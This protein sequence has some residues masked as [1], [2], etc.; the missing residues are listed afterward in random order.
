LSIRKKSKSRKD[1]LSE[2]NKHEIDFDKQLI[3]INDNINILKKSH[4]VLIDIQKKILESNKTTI[5][6]ISMSKF[7]KLRKEPI[8]INDKTK[9]KRVKVKIHGKG[10]QL[11]DE[12]FGAEIKTKKQFM[13]KTNDLIVAEIDAKVG[14]FGII[15]PELESAIVSN[16]YFLYEIDESVM[17]PDFGLYS[18]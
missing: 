11:R 10:I 8:T 15:P 6:V 14:G 1:L 7:L 12:V 3:E 16:H 4:K 17:R 5:P 13:V 18:L 2:L 9:Y